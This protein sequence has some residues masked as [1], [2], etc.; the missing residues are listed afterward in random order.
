MF[1]SSLLTC[2]LGAGAGDLSCSGLGSAGYTEVGQMVSWGISRSCTVS[3][4][5]SLLCKSPV[6]VAAAEGEL[7]AA[8][9]MMTGEGTKSDASIRGA[10]QQI[11]VTHFLGGSSQAEPYRLGS[12]KMVGVSLSSLEMARS[13][14]LL[15]H[16]H[17]PPEPQWG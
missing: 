13:G 17:A 12:G 3:C 8:A 6:V 16:R 1:E 14:S 10:A 4:R 7:S 5:Q 15:G 11:R 9:R 2:S